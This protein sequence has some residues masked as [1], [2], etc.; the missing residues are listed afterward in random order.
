MTNSPSAV[1]SSGSP[2]ANISPGSITKV[3]TFRQVRHDRE[4]QAKGN[5]G[6]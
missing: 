3:R 2:W 1:R 5:P 6:D 4:R